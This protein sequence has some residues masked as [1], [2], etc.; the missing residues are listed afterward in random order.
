MI[1]GVGTDQFYMDVS[2]YG[3][4]I[5]VPRVAGGTRLAVCHR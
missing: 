3:M 5:G 2:L 4:G 1:I